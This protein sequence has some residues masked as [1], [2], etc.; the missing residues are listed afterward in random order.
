MQNSSQHT[1]THEPHHTT[2]HRRVQPYNNNFEKTKSLV[3][4]STII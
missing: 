2:I 1:N 4:D 3:K